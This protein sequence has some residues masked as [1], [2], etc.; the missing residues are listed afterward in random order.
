[1]TDAAAIQR[2]AAARHSSGVRDTVV[3]LWRDGAV[4]QSVGI[5][6]GLRLALGVVGWATLIEFPTHVVG[7]DWL[8][9][10]TPA[11]DRLWA[12]INPWQRWDSLWYQHIAASWY[13][14]RSV[15]FFPLYPALVRPVGLLFGGQQ[16]QVALA[17]LLVST[18]AIAVALVFL[19]RLVS[20]DIDGPTANRTMLYIAISP[21]A[22]LFFAPYTEALFLMVTVGA[23]LAA[24]RRRWVATAIAAAGASVSRPTGILI[25]APILI[26]LGIDIWNRRRAGLSIVRWQYGL[27]VALPIATL[28]AF[29]IKY[30]QPV[31]GFVAAQAPWG[32]RVAW[33][34]TSLL[35]SA[36]TVIA[37]GHPEEPT[38][39]AF[40]LLLLVAVPLMCF[41]V[42]WSYV[43]YAAVSIIPVVFHETPVT[44]LG[45]AARYALVVFP[46][47]VLL[48]LAGR[49]T[50]IDRA[51]TVMFPVL[52]AFEFMSFINY[53]IF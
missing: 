9:L 4:R 28:G 51:I 29:W 42:P 47:F 31:G 13:D 49:K 36:H 44:P 40:A 50:V 38:N 24:R 21:L 16:T 1:M 10:Q 5:V 15:H 48:A 53:T 45:G 43:A 8:Q 32:E 17:A 46:I 25:F 41:R 26:E 39:L 37:G 19:H 18:V 2:P 12:L 14:D 52:M 34:W 27:V 20:A 6:V 23:V 22:F 30:L 7:G 3:S 35:D 11:S 33:P